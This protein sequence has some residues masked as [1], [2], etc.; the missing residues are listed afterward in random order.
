ML[1]VTTVLGEAAAIVDPKGENEDLSVLC[2][3]VA[4]ALENPDR[5]SGW[6]AETLSTALR[7]TFGGD[8]E[9]A[10]EVARQLSA[11]DAPPE[12]RK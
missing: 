1:D 2:G 4:W 11:S 5:Y 7:W 12:P 9:M 3:L 8:A 10:D 6:D